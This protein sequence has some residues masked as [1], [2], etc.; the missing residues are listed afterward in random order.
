[1]TTIGQK[2]DAGQFWSF[3]SS[4]SSSNMRMEGVW[5]SSFWP[6]FFAQKK[7]AKKPIASN[8]LHPIKK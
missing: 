4:S 1:M 3:I 2:D 5:R 6:L 8:K 7:A